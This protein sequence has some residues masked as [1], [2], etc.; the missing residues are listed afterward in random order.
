VD[1][2]LFA[3][4]CATG[5]QAIIQ[6]VWVYEHSIDFDGL[7]RFHHN[8]GHG[9]L[10][11]RI[12][13]SPLPFARYRWGSDLGPEIDIAESPRTRTE[14]SD[15]ADERSQLATGSEWGPGWHLSVFDEFSSAPTASKRGRLGEVREGGR[16]TETLIDDLLAA[17]S[18]LERG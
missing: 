17:R 2:A 15:W 1:Q 11:R 5:Q 4:Q 8:L 14:L 7:K 16:M 3:A 9:L 13:R 18:R 12:E 10:G 6:C